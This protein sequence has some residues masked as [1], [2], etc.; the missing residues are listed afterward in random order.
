MGVEDKEYPV[1]VTDEM[2]TKYEDMVYKVYLKSFSQYKYLRDDLLQC[3]RWGVFLA[4]QRYERRAKNK[5]N[6]TVYVW[7]NIRTKM[8]HYIKHE[9][10]HILFD[11][12]DEYDFSELLD[13]FSLSKTSNIDLK[14]AISTLSEEEQHQVEQWQNYVMFKDMGFKH[15]QT[16]QQRFQRILKRLKGKL[17][18]YEL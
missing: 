16:A 4:Y 8:G 6:F 15:K 9:R 14:R 1:K 3:G 2:I 17:K 18:N 13:D 5:C 10:N 12:D 11:S 7:L